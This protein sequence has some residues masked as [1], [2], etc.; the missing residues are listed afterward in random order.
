M[1]FTES[2]IKI[3]NSHGN[4]KVIAI[5]PARFPDSLVL[6]ID[7]SGLFRNNIFKYNKMR[8]NDIVRENNIIDLILCICLYS[9]TTVTADQKKVA[10][11]DMPRAIQIDVRR[12]IN[13]NC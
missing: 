3:I 7:R 9:G 2:H 8:Q 10:K 5:I 11:I 4:A 1:R 12:V 6:K 13:F